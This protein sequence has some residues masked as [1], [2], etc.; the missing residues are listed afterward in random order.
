VD[1][2]L[3]TLQYS[4]QVVTILHTLQYAV[5]VDTILH[6][7]QYGVQV[8][9]ILNTLQ[10]AK[11]TQYCTHLYSDLLYISF[12][13]SCNIENCCSEYADVYFIN[14]FCNWNATSADA[15]YQRQ[16]QVKFLRLR[17][18]G[19]F[20][21]AFTLEYSSRQNEANICDMAEGSLYQTTT[22]ISSH[23]AITCLLV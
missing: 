4:V 18:S 14:G 16:F 23:L 12:S 6:T 21:S 11:W 7:L 13:V 17:A 2:I 10:Y 20:L 1:T 15:T 3:H 9:P 19:M 5:Q 22:R 8:D